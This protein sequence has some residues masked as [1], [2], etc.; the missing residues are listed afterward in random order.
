MDG[1]WL[2]ERV[3]GLV[4]GGHAARLAVVGAVAGCGPASVD[5]AEGG[6]GAAST[7]ADAESS[8]G[9]ADASSGGDTGDTP[10][11][12]LP[13]RLLGLHDTIEGGHELRYLELDED[14]VVGPSVLAPE[15]DP[16]ARIERLTPLRSS[17][18][19][20][21]VAI[22][23]P[24][25][26]YL[27]HVDADGVGTAQE[28]A[29]DGEVSGLAWV[30]DARSLVFATS[31][32]TYR[33]EL[34]ASGPA[35]AVEIA[36][37]ALRS[38]LT[39]AT[40]AGTWVAAGFSAS[41]EPSGCYVA[42]V[43]PERPTGWLEVSEGEVPCNVVGFA[44]DAIVF[45]SGDEPARLLRRTLVDG[46]LGDTTVL[47]EDVAPWPAV[48]PHGVVYRSGG[49]PGVVTFVRVDGD[50]FAPPVPLSGQAV[51]YPVTASATGRELVF[52]AGSGAALVDLAASDPLA[53]PLVFPA[54]YVGAASFI[55]VTPDRRH[56]FAVARA[57]LGGAYWEETTSL[58]QLDIS[59][60]G[61]A[62]VLIGETDR[63]NEEINTSSFAAIAFAADGTSL[64]FAEDDGTELHGDVVLVPLGAEGPG[65]AVV[66][67][68][69]LSPHLAYSPDSAYLA[70]GAGQVVDRT[71]APVGTLSASSWVWWER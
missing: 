15:L 12:S 30:E 37:P 28:I 38:D 49:D 16:T 61:S 10:A 42:R 9:A 41:G 19:V 18:Y 71:G 45:T 55:A 66:L 20:A 68:D 54:G 17:E 46:E 6:S 58:W 11:P 57:G 36:G 35:D 21:F 62:P 39:R 4:R 44:G 65:E 31:T 22:D 40:T 34:T 43:D 2:R 13:L 24:R 32:T 47:D 23:G 69:D 60:A 59:G 67:D 64:A 3:R 14:E 50:T 52:L 53:Q 8:T 27:A 5:A 70:F 33:V 29:A 56:A 26:L 7:T 1:H 63:T 51:P 25:R 48:V